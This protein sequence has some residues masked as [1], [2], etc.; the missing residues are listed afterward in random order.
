MISTEIGVRV[1]DATAFRLVS[2]F[3][4]YVA[5]EAKLSTGAERFGIYQLL[6]VDTV[7]NV[8]GV[9]LGTA[10]AA[11]AAARPMVAMLPLSR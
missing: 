9:A 10:W 3:P 8:I 6:S 11:T 4:T 2:S 1:N 7:N 5:V